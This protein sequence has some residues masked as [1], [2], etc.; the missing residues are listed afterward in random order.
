MTAFSYDLDD[1]QELFFSKLLLRQTGI[2]Y[3]I[4][5]TKFWTDNIKH[6]IKRKN[7]KNVDSLIEKL[8]CGDT[9]LLI[10]LLTAFKPDDLGFYKNVDQLKFFSETMIPTFIDKGA[11]HKNLAIWSTGCKKGQETYTYAIL[12]E[13]FFKDLTDWKV[14]V[15]GTDIFPNDIDFASIGCYPPE[16]FQ[17]DYAKILRDTYF[18]NKGDHYYL[19]NQYVRNCT[20]FAIRN[21]QDAVDNYQ[22]FDLICCRAYF[23]QMVPEWREKIFDNFN[24]VL[25][26][27][28]YLILNEIDSPLGITNHFT[29][30]RGHPG[31]YKKA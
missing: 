13:K 10:E 21:L 24:T 17:S 22:Q 2:D 28:G 8:K 1:N 4:Q 16:S 19:T 25:K 9:E 15:Q 29:A 18:E 27:W 14:H 3:Q 11:H 6:L 7:F 5:D 20:H 12:L 31:I 30:T 26:P 23:K